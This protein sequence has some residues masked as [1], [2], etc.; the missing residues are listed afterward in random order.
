MQLHLLSLLNEMYDFCYIVPE[1]RA[2]K[3]GGI[4]VSMFFKNT[5]PPEALTIVLT[6]LSTGLF[7]SAVRSVWTLESDI[8]ALWSIV[9]TS[10]STRLFD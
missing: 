10:L 3:K 1:T 6:L 8:S 2:K 5:H 7:D 9:L 4:Y